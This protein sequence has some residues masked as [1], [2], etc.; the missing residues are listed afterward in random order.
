M[1]VYVR[2]HAFWFYEDCKSSNCVVL[3]WFTF[4]KK[5]LFYFYKFLVLNLQRLP[6]FLPFYKQFQCCFIFLRKVSDNNLFYFCEIY[7]TSL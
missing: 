6:D 4:I 3:Q 5:G 2:A 7:R 1:K